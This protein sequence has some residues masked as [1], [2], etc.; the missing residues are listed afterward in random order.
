MLNKGHLNSNSFISFSKNRRIANGFAHGGIIVVLGPG[1]YPAVE[2]GRNGFITN[3][4]EREVLLA[5]G[6][7]TLRK[8]RRLNGNY[9]VNYTPK[10]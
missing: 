4:R 10:S 2:N 1:K 3:Q 5:P 6:R 8:N 7:L 9:V